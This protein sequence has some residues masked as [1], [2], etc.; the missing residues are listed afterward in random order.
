MN[1]LQ[2]VEEIRQEALRRIRGLF[3]EL[4]EDEIDVTISLHTEGD[5]LASLEE[6]AKEA[7]WYFDEGLEPRYAAWY[8]SVDN[9]TPGGA[10]TVYL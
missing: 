6:S 7:G 2:A 10:V 9:D 5:T 4:G 3:S 1:R 8:S